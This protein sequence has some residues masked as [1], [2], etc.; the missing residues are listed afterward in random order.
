[1]VELLDAYERHLYAVA[2]GRG[3]EP[4]AVGQMAR[5]AVAALAWVK[6]WSTP[7]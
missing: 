7:S 3:G 4:V 5:H 6:H 2:R 1:M